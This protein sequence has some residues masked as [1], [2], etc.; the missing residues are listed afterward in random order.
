M[1]EHPGRYYTGQPKDFD[2]ITIEEH[3]SEYIGPELLPMVRLCGYGADDMLRGATAAAAPE[4]AAA[5][6]RGEGTFF[7]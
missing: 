5:A 3:S 2:V 1:M 7:N 4:G 6:P